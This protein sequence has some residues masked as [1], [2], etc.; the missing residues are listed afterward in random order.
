MMEGE[1]LAK[2]PKILQPHINSAFPATTCQVASVLPNG[3]AQI[4]MRGSVLV[5]DD[6]HIAWWER[7]SGTT[8]DNLKDGDK[9]TVFYRN[10]KLREDGTLPAG[11]VARFYGIA[12]V[13][14]SGDLRDQIWDKV[15]QPEKDRDPERKGWAVLMK[16][17]RA[18]SLTGKPLTLD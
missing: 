13:V 8:T 11:G 10:P 14:K 12:K 3:Y 9:V 18:E 5:F 16:V 7:G 6:E 17:E 4:T 2:V 1:T 15:V